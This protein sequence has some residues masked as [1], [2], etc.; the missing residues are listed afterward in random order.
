[1]AEV[2]LVVVKKALFDASDSMEVIG[3]VTPSN[4]ANKNKY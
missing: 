4:E 3:R 1:M 2:S